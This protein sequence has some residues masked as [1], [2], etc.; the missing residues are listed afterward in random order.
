MEMFLDE[1]RNGEE[2]GASE[3]WS[4]G[5]EMDVHVLSTEEAKIMGDI[6]T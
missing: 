5:T 6:S 4:K 1:P 3:W 2:R